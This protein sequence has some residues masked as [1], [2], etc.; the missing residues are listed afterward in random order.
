MFDAD[1]IL[2]KMESELQNILSVGLKLLKLR[3]MEF[4]DETCLWICYDYDHH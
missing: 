4:R 2:E 1:L 3:K